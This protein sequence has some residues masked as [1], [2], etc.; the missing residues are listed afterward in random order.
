[1]A[2]QTM[3]TVSSMTIS[4]AEPNNEPYSSRPSK[5]M[6]ASSASSVTIG[7]DPPEGNK[8]LKARPSGMP[9]P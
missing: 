3:S 8:A 9:P 1:M 2:A 7:A 5:D 6:G 4:E